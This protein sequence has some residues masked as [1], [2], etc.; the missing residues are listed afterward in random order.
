MILALGA[1]GPR[2][3]SRTGPLF[4]IFSKCF[5]R[6]NSKDDFGF[7]YYHLF[8]CK[9]L[10]DRANKEIKSKDRKQQDAL[11]LREN[12]GVLRTVKLSL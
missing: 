7:L 6:R 12:M 3:D 10:N 11:F 2:F 1:I 4:T 8:G 9:E 5:A